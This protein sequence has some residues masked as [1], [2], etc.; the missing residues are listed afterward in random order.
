MYNTFPSPLGVI[1]FSMNVKKTNQDFS[2][3]FPSPLGVIYFSILLSQLACVRGLVSVPSRGYLF[4]N[5]SSGIRHRFCGKGFPSPLG[6][7]YF[8]MLQDASLSGTGEFPSPLGV[9]YFSI[10]HTEH[11]FAEKVSVPSRGYLFLN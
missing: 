1:Y 11:Y 9:I 6:V 4:L 3:L 10:R 7:I 8:S 5:I 2:N